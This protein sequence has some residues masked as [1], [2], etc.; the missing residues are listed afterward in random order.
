MKALT[1]LQRISP[2]T[3]FLL[4]GSVLELLY[5]LLCTLMPFNATN[6]INSPSSTDWSWIISLS[7]PLVIKTSVSSLRFSDPGFHFILLSLIIIAL[8][9]VYLYAVGNAFHISNNISITSRWL[10][11]PVIGA[12]TFGI[13][14]LFLP[15]FFNYEANSYVFKSLAL[16]S[17]LINCVLIW[18][19]LLKT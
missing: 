8:S 11:L 2:L 13:T 6:L 9:S 18:A 14:L 7:Q 3:R 10:F 4:L 1:S 17:H 19:R 15:S 5:L 12:T 16:L